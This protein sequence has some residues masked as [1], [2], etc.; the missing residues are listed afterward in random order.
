MVRSL[1]SVVDETSLLLMSIQFH[2]NRNSESCESLILSILKPVSYLPNACKDAESTRKQQ[3]RRLCI[4]FRM[5][6]N[7]RSTETLNSFFFEA[8]SKILSSNEPHSL[9]YLLIDALSLFVLEKPVVQVNELIEE[10]LEPGSGLPTTEDKLKFH[11]LLPSLLKLMQEASL[12]AALGLQ[13]TLLTV[14]TLKLFLFLTSQ[15]EVEPTDPRDPLFDLPKHLI[16][17][18]RVLEVLGIC[19]RPRNGSAREL[20]TVLLSKP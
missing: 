11:A 17:C 3:L 5:T 6:S 2:A 13:P 1:V 16:Q 20:S 15:L 14:T 19:S 10:V 4:F 12:V 18:C 9:K 8:V 7:N